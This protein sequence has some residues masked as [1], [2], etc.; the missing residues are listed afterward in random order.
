[1]LQ[2]A[3]MLNTQDRRNSVAAF[4]KSIALPDVI[5]LGRPRKLD[6]QVLTGLVAQLHDHLVE[7]FRKR[8]DAVGASFSGPLR[9]VQ[10]FL[11]QLSRHFDVDV[12]T[13][14]YDNVLTRLLDGFET[15]FSPATGQFEA[16]R[17]GKSHHLLHLHGSVHFSMEGLG[18]DLHE[19]S[20]V[21]NLADIEAS[22]AFGRNL[23]ETTEGVD[24]LTSTFVAGYGKQIQMR[25]DPF[26]TYYAR[27]SNLASAAD[28]LLFLGYG[29][30]D[31]HINAILSNFPREAGKKVVIV[32]Y[33]ND[34]DEPLAFRP[35]SDD[36]VWN[37]GR[38]IKTDLNG[39][40]Q[41]GTSSPPLEVGELKRNR[42]FEVSE[43][44]HKPLAIWYGGFMEAVRN[45][46]RILAQ[47]I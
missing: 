33:G 3:S 38:T 41:E 15:G 47:L 4:F 43:L 29:F 24:Y 27:F 30:G 45:S 1:M 23:Q 19:I 31:Q 7:E 39:M 20:W 36:W 9:Q 10:A 6:G 37:L 18:S 16:I 2:L 14:N 12:V 35:S 25:R 13:A 46:N 34:T 21:P 22:N 28:R 8:C 11:R 32:G 42:T 26:L 17:L 40:V 5:Y 44:P